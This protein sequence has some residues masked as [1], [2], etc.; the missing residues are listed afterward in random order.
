[1]PHYSFQPSVCTFLQMIPQ[2]HTLPLF[3]LSFRTSVKKTW[4]ESWSPAPPALL[5]SSRRSSE[6]NPHSESLHWCFC[7]YDIKYHIF[8][9]W[10]FFR[11]HIFDIRALILWPSS[12]SVV[13]L[14][15]FRNTTT[16][17]FL[18]L[19]LCFLKFYYSQIYF[20]VSNVYAKNWIHFYSLPD[21]DAS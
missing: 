11:Y 9:I 20:E 2:S 16:T 1:M 17:N 7:E 13:C 18:I 10:Y 19:C 5:E 14:S 21:L 6:E 3:S 4:G 15:H 8:D 12:C